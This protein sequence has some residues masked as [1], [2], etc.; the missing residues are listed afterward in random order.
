MKD[1]RRLIEKY[2]IL[3]LGPRFDRASVLC[4]KGNKATLLLGASLCPKRV[5][6]ITYIVNTDSLQGWYEMLYDIMDSRYDT[7]IFAYNVHRVFA[8]HIINR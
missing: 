2:H 3:A 8:P 7:Y 4:T 6:R 5:K 1:G